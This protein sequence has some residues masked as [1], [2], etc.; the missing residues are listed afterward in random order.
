MSEATLFRSNAAIIRDGLER[1]NSGEKVVLATVVS[2]WGS[3]PRPTG[4]VMILTET[5]HFAGSVSGGC[6]EEELFAVIRDD[7]PNEC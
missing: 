5:G 4:S 7:F 1:I 3:S 6:I 2:T